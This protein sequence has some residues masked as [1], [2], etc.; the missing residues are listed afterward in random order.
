MPD[1]RSAPVPDLRPD[2]HLTGP[3][4]APLLV[5]YGDFTCPRCALAWTRLKPQR[6]RIAFR[7]FALKAKH[8]R[9]VPLAHAAEAAAR[10]GA[11]WPFLESLYADQGHTDDPHL[12]RRCSD[13]GLDLDRFEA[14][15]R[16]AA[17]QERVARDVREALRAGATATPTLFRDGRIATMG[18]LEVE[19]TD[20]SKP[21]PET[22]RW[23]EGKTYE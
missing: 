20:E 6:L 15:R 14:D 1:L 21:P 16:D 9:A 11:F 2:D 4:G 19:E 7:H 18:G 5:F 10:Q 13:L 3:A 12:W 22:D 17:V 8:P 23:Q